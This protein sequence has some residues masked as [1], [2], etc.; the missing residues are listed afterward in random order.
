MK[1]FCT[2]LLGLSFVAAGLL[3]A[4]AVTVEDLGNASGEYVTIDVTGVGKLPVNAGI[5]NLDVG[6][7]SVQ[8]FCIDPFHF[9]NGAMP[10]YAIV[11]LTSAPKDHLMSA[12]TALAIERLWGSYYSPSMS[13]NDAAGLQ[14][15]FWEL[16]GGSDFKLC[17]NNDY[18]AAGF[19]SAVQSPNY[20]GPVADLVGLTGPGQDLAVLRSSV[21]R[22]SESVPETGSTLALLTFALLSLSIAARRVPQ[23]AF[24]R[25]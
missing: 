6:G 23:L 8:G 5:L 21:D 19:L 18:G 15:A 4:T 10:G 2:S 16:T 13:A 17:S 12:G 9:S 20:D 24:T 3:N 7:V 25:A 22:L 1:G 14:I 11:E